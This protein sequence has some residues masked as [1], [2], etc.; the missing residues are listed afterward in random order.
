MNGLTDT[1]NE[2][3][4][5][6]KE[7]YPH[8]PTVCNTIDKVASEMLQEINTNKQIDRYEIRQ[9]L[10]KYGSEFKN[11]RIKAEKGQL[12]VARTIGCSQAIISFIENGYMLPPKVIE[13]AID[14]L[15]KKSEGELKG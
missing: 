15:Y 4:K 7:H 3:A 8:T 11:R 5:R 9:Y 1:I 10:N 6:L 13:I 14:K 2:F 12:E